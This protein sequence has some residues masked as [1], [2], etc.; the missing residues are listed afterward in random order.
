MSFRR[1]FAI[2]FLLFA[3]GAALVVAGLLGGRALAIQLGFES[4]LLGFLWLGF[5]ILRRI[6]QRL[7]FRVGNRLFV[8]YVLIG[9]L[10]MLMVFCLAGLL[11]YLLTGQLAV[12]RA[13]RE[14]QQALQLLREKAAAMSQ[15]LEPGSDALARR[16]LFAAG[17]PAAGLG[18]ALR[19]L[20]G[21]LDGEGPLD[22]ALL[23]PEGRVQ[24]SLEAV[25]RLGKNGPHFLAVVAPPT[26]AGSLVVYQRIEP[27]LRRQIED[28]THASISF[29]QA[30][31]A[32]AKALQEGAEPD[33]QVSVSGG[34]VNFKFDGGDDADASDRTTIRTFEKDPPLVAESGLV[35][36]PIVYF[37]RSVELPYIDWTD[38]DWHSAIEEDDNFNMV[39]QTSVAR[40]YLALFDSA[41][42]DD[43]NTAIGENMVAL[44]LYLA[45]ATLTLY[46]LAA[47][48]AGVLVYRIA[49]ATSCLHFGFTEV[50]KGNFQVDLTF[51]GKDQL[52]GLVASF[53]RMAR[54][55][56]GSLEERAQR[57]AIER[58]LEIAR[59]LQRSLLPPAD[60][61]APGFEI[62]AD[63]VPAAAIGGDFYHFS[64]WS[65][66][67]LLVAIADVSGHGLA[68]GIVMS[69]A[70]ALLSA[71]STDYCPCP[72]LLRRLDRELRSHTGRRNFVTLALC[73]FDRARGKLELSNAGHP[74]PYRLQADG[75]LTAIENPSRPLAVGLP[76]DFRSVCTEIAAG[77]LFVLYSDG[78]IEA[79]APSGEVFGFDRFENVLRTCAGKTAAETRDC[80][81]DAWRSFTGTNCPEDDRTLLVLKVL[82]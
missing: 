2:A 80:V 7:L 43:I 56:A 29:P 8:S 66:G 22:P 26:A 75:C 61:C 67:R 39:A 68:T 79:L 6:F 48:I 9:V 63:F 4:V 31:L 15:G 19:P 17:R 14:L 38:G 77:D 65:D 51:R 13:E 23:L 16:A 18:W 53:N 55:L 64:G 28:A 59:Q 78:V 70:K 44:P 35:G 76:Q 57:E 50:E 49:R 37:P 5:H 47:V 58:E 41:T 12:R 81:L 25:G 34:S 46:F 30:R 74:Y 36:K 60:Y 69:A 40:E 73:A 11:V 21:D 24:T 20:A 10:P 45:M 33:M 52:A 72:E 1:I 3:L 82:D 27:E 42:A 54:H 32:A 62:A 71:L